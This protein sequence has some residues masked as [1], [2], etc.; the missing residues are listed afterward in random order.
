M[1]LLSM[2]HE[3]NTPGTSNIVLLYGKEK[4][5]EKKN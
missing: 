4:E 5:K 3:Q 2:D 1:I